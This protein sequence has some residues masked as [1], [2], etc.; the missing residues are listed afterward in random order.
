MLLSNVL[1]VRM[2]SGCEALWVMSSRS[3]SGTRT[4]GKPTARR[5]GNSPP[6]ARPTTF[7]HL[8]DVQPVQVAANVEELLQRIAAPSVKLQLAG[9]RM[10]F[11]W[12][13]VG[14]VMPMNP[15]SA[16]R[17]PKHSVK[18]CKTPVM[19]GR[20]GSRTSRRHRHIDY[21]WPAQIA[22]SSRS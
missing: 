12:L 15:A 14:Q 17:G 7:T 5:P 19:T 21:R 6:G 1:H 18:K 13:V 4:P 3:I 9:I 16:V 11:D 22:R 10:L 20:R 8:R 2:H